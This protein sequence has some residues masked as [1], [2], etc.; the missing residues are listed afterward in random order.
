M[1][2]YLLLFTLCFIS[3]A[4]FGQKL[5]LEKASPFTAVKWD[6]EKPIVQFN[7]E[8]F[9][10]EKLD[11]YST[12]EILDF[13]KQNFGDKWQ[14][15]FSEDLV[16]VLKQMGASPEETVKLI[17]SKETKTKTVTGTY[18]FKN[19]QRVFAYNK[20]NENK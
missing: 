10:L 11:K 14:K 13:C 7:D 4:G 9:A 19:R 16:A 8:W 18:T 6:D 3:L 15:R 5:Q 20:S 12:K 1:R 17:L 2:T